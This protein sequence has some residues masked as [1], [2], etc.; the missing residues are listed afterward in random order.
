MKLQTYN[1]L[2]KLRKRMH[3]NITNHAEAHLTPTE[4]LVIIDAII[5]MWIQLRQ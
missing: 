4:V 3:E 2:I 5:E 1:T